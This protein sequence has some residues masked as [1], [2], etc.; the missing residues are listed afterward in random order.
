VV[1]LLLPLTAAG[2]D[3]PGA[4][5]APD[6]DEAVEALAAA[7]REG[8]LDTSFSDDG[9]VTDL[10]LANAL[11]FQPNGKIVVAGSAYMANNGGRI[12]SDFALTRYNANGTLD[13]TFGGDGKVTT[14]L[15]GEDVV[16][17]VALQPDGKIVVAGGSDINDPSNCHGDDFALA[18]YNTNGTLDT[19]FSGDGKIR[20]GFSTCSIDEPYALV[21]QPDGKIVVAG[22][23][24]GD[25]ALARYNPDGT[26]DTT[27]GPSHTGKVTTDIR[28][29]YLDEAF[30]LALQPDGKIVVAGTAFGTDTKD[31]AL[32]RYNLDGT[33]DTTFGPSH[34]GK[35]ITDFGG[36]AKARALVIQPDSKI[37]VAGVSWTV[38]VDEDGNP[39][40]FIAVFALARYTATGA[41]DTTFS[42]D[43]K[44]TA[45]LGRGDRDEAYALTFQV[46]GKIIVAGTSFDAAGDSDVAL[47]R[48]NTNGT[49]DM[50]FNSD[51][52]V[53]T[54]LSGGN[55][56]FTRAVA[57]QP[58]DGRI[59]VAAFSSDGFALARYHAITCGGV[60]VTRIGTAGNDTIVGTNGPD[61][62]YGFGG[63][64][65]ILG[66]GGNDL[67]CGGTGNDTLRGGDG[68]DML[69]GGAGTDSCDGGAHVNGD[70]A[71]DCESVTGVR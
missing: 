64:D 36:V 24:N 25:F 45:D 6:G 60:V 41:L 20:T 50:S 63:N 5:T 43:G 28:D 61:V 68:D 35:I 40:E 22:V 11:A 8:D 47:V 7:P 4:L 33:L 55:Y 46:D 38:I 49:L 31:F 26:L 65:T 54:D 12:S 15:G 42:S 1:L 67:L 69:R 29:G 59:V 2:Q 70:E 10:H 37:V 58:R 51:G 34:T 39:I 3:T 32:A 23:S 71:F 13:T 27:F 56:D 53:T 21:I 14:D 57:I 19:R 66:L 48:Y 52:K 16:Y 17:A 62:I 44:V 9:K 30:A 18:R